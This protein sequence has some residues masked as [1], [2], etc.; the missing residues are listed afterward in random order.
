MEFLMIIPKFLDCI[1]RRM[2]VPFTGA[3]T[4]CENLSF[5]WTEGVGGAF[6]TPK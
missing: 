6:E 1:S 2:T 5:L 4:T 3:G